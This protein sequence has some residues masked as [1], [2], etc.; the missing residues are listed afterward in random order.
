MFVNYSCH[1]RTACGLIFG[2]NAKFHSRAK[3]VIDVIIDAANEASGT[4]Y[5]ITGAMKN[6]SNSLRE[7]ERS[8][9]ATDFINS[10]SQRL[11]TQAADI[12]R[13]ASDDRDLIYKGMKIV[14]VFPLT[15][16]MFLFAMCQCRK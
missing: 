9:Q 12:E 4:I 1:F 10:T 8:S 16:F 2:G 5:D 14:Y 3:T 11:D 6:M 15:L 7:V 13:N